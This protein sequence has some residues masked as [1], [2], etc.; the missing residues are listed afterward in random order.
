M[1]LLGL[2]WGCLDKCSLVD[3]ISV[4]NMVWIGEYQVFAVL[5]YFKSNKYVIAKGVN[6]PENVQLVRSAVQRL[7]RQSTQNLAVAL[8]VSTIV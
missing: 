7:P 8:E 6:S 3:P 1:V 2:W 5:P 4:A